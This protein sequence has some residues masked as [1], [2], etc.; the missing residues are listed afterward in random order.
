MANPYPLRIPGNLRSLLQIEADNSHVT[1]ASY[2]IRACWHELER[3]HRD[4]I[5]APATATKPSLDALRAIC[6]GSVHGS[7]AIPD[8]EPDTPLM[9]DHVEWVESEGESYSCCRPA[10]HKGPCKRGYKL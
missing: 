8:A 5:P 1:L 9:C 6:A 10:G 4:P 2:I 7:P 3:H